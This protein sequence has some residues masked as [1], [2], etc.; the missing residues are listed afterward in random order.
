MLHVCFR[1]GDLS[2]KEHA[3]P[4]RESVECISEL[5]RGP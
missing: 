2:G 1:V 3:L 5:T 4:G